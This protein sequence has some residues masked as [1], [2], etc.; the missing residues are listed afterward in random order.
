ML[1]QG[2]HILA[3][4][5]TKKAN[6]TVALFVNK[7]VIRREPNVHAR[8]GLTSSVRYFLTYLAGPIRTGRCLS[9]LIVYCCKL[10]YVSEA[11]DRLEGL[12]SPL[13]PCHGSNA[14]AVVSIRAAYE[15][16]LAQIGHRCSRCQAGCWAT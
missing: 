5:S 6:L 4:A 3:E 13:R 14:S 11:P 12:I 15:A 7:V 1:G 9:M 16:N 10:V 8:P 2:A